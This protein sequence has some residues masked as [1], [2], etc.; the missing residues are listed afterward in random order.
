MRIHLGIY[1]QALL[2]YVLSLCVV[3][4]ALSSTA[5]ADLVIDLPEITLQS[6]GVD[7]VAGE[8]DVTLTLTGADIISPPLL[9]SFNLDLSVTGSSVTFADPSPG[10][11]DPLFIGGDFSFVPDPIRVRAAHDIFDES[12]SSVEASSGA[13][14]IKVMFQIDAGAEG[15]WDLTL[16][17]LNELTNS[18]A[19]PLTVT[20]LS[21]SITVV[22]VPE[23][24]AW[25]CLGSCLVG[26]MAMSRMRT[27]STGRA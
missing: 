12:P 18:D 16:G 14:L 22:A 3:V 10:A 1:D 26:V 7:P 19:N 23:A 5:Q 11:A 6:N 9:S 24:R 25:L 13:G 4:G 15:T 21:G 2:S 20:L 27:A 8:F 17:N